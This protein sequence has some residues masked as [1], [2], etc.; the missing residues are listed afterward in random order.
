MRGIAQI[1][2]S[3]TY[4]VDRDVYETARSQAAL[5]HALL[6]HPNDRGKQLLDEARATFEQLEAALDLQAI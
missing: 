6:L 2:R 4:F 5:G 1:E 3:L